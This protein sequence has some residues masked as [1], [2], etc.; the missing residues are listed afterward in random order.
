MTAALGRVTRPLNPPDVIIVLAS[1]HLMSW[2]DRRSTTIDV[3]LKSIDR[4]ARERRQ[5]LR[6]SR[7][8]ERGL[9]G[10]ANRRRRP[11]RTSLLTSVLITFACSV[12]K[13]PSYLDTL[14][15]HRRHE[16]P[17]QGCSDNAVTAPDPADSPS[18]SR[19]RSGEQADRRAMVESIAPIRT[20][21]RAGCDQHASSPCGAAGL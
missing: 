9:L 10:I 16:R 15:A 7:S 4:V 13:Q 17:A 1:R 6:E 12:H 8:L 11:L 14:A 18:R 5:N 3:E 20:V 21:D 2:V 19:P